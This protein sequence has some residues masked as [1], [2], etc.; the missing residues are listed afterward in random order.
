MKV[1]AL[2]TDH[3]GKFCIRADAVKTLEKKEHFGVARHRQQGC[4]VNDREVLDDFTEV[5]EMLKLEA[6]WEIL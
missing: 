1:L 3:G 2:H 6:E 4:I 5:L